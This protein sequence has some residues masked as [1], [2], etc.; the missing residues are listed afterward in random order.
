MLLT[1]S[2][3]AKILKTSE[4]TVRRL[5]RSGELPAQRTS[6]G[7]R[8]FDRADVDRLARERAERHTAPPSPEAA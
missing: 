5:E 8:L 6:N 4:G 2:S 3:A 7:M 1:V